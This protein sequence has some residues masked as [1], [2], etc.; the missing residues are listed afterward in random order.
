MKKALQALIPIFL[1]CVMT[2]QPLHILPEEKPQLPPEASESWYQKAINNIAASEYNIHY[3]EANCGL[4]GHNRQNNFYVDLQGSGFAITPK[5]EGEAPV[6]ISL[7]GIYAN[8][9]LALKPDVKGY[10]YQNENVVVFWHRGFKEQ[11]I[12]TPAG[13][14]QNFIVE[15]NLNANEI[16]VL[17]QVTGGLASTSGDNQMRLRTPKGTIINYKDLKVW[18]ATGRYLPARMQLL[19][20]NQ[21]ALVV[22]NAL[23]AA[24][25]ITIDPLSSSPDWQVESNQIGA[26]MGCSVAGAGDVNVDGYSDV[27]VGAMHYSNGQF[28]E[29][30]AFVYYGSASGLSINPAWQVESNKADAN[31]GIS[32]ADA[33]DVNGDGFDDV[34]VG[35]PRYHNGQLWEGAAFVYHGSASGLSNTAAWQIE[36][37]NSSVFL[38]SSVAGAGDVNGDGFGDVIVGAPNYG[39]GQTNEGAAFVYHGSATGLNTSA[40]WQIESN[41]DHSVLGYSVAKAGDVN[42]DGYGDVIVGAPWFTNG[43]DDEGAAFVYLGSAVGLDT[44]ASW[45]VEGNQENAAMGAAIA[46]AGDVNGD[47][48]GDIIVSAYL[49][50]NGQQKEG[51]AYIFHGTSSGLDTTAAT[52]L[53][54]NQAWLN[55]AGSV[56]GAG[57]VNGD[58][59]S[60]IILGTH[61]YKNGEPFEGAVFVYHG[62]AF[63]VSTTADWQSESN[64]A[65][66]WFGIPVAS[67]G[68]V[69]GDGFSDVIVGA[70]RFE[71][72][73][74]EEGAAFVFHGSS[75]GL[76]TTEEETFEGIKH[77]IAYALN[78][79]LALKMNGLSGKDVQISVLDIAGRVLQTRLYTNVESEISV[80]FVATAGIYVVQ[81][82][83]KKTG[84]LYS[85]KLVW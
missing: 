61:A 25:P 81:I 83:N 73:H 26:L 33:G 7:K 68:D 38:G 80:P 64:M 78:G 2:A 47:G 32:V 46:G 52:I 14:R 10:D 9:A 63:G 70:T 28:E 44:I 36:S 34:I 60:D 66:S 67:V 16:R 51:A 30:A 24:Y 65:E 3:N 59:Y 75:T 4:R 76:S 57:D 1:P 17:L 13:L 55:F 35:S 37:N 56:S 20:D 54:G 85:Q 19:P 74:S 6:L 43:Q 50:S 39:N 58:G 48:Y 69:N 29:G 41:Y 21:I 11:Y 72:G 82:E 71:N 84:K 12:N 5:T 27:I 45:Q 62:S 8:N 15:E 22:S 49:F 18:D 40:S 23:N 42:G 79:N 53:E 31:F 77:P